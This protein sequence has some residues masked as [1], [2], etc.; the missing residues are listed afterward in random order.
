MSINA[1]AIQYPSGRWGFVGFAV[2]AALAYEGDD[3]L[4]AVAKQ[5]GPG[6]AQRIAARD[7]RNFRALSWD[8]EADALAARAEWEARQ[9]A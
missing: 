6:F 4:L 7:G 8:N 9:C 3:D 2:P 1:H 5:C